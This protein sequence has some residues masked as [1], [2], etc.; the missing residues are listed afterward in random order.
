MTENTYDPAWLKELLDERLVS[1]I[2][3]WAVRDL[4]SLRAWVRGHDF[5]AD[6]SIDD[7]RQSLGVLDGQP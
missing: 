2:M 3:E 7:M 5:Y 6:W 1:D 4:D